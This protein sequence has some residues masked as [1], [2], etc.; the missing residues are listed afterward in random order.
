MN[1][2]ASL[3]IFVCQL[4]SITQDAMVTKS[5]KCQECDV[6][7]TWIVKFRYFIISRLQYLDIEP[8]I[9]H[10]FKWFSSLNE[11]LSFTSSL[12]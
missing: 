5:L 6:I 4:L 1:Y 11:F 10:A 9:L 12:I 2:F 3:G 7:S 8:S